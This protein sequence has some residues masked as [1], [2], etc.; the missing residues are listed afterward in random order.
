[1]KLLSAFLASSALAQDCPAGERLKKNSVREVFCD[2]SIDKTVAG[3]DFT[4]RF[5]K[6]KL[7][8]RTSMQNS[9]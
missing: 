7:F 9:A 6:P 8:I 4:V 5:L 1:M 3:K 2:K